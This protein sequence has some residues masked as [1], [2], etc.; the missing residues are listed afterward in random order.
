MSLLGLDVGTS[1]VKAAVHDESGRLLSSARCAVAADRPGP[2]WEQADAEMVWAAACEVI[3]AVA[4]SDAVRHDPIT[5]LAIS[6]SGDEAFPVDAGGR[7]LAPC[8]M[9]GDQRGA[10]VESSTR[11]RAARAQWYRW[12]G[13]VP[14]RMDPVNRWLWLQSEEPKIT[15]S[16]RWFLGWHEFLTLRLC[17]TPV[18]DPS[19]AAKWL[20]FDSSRGS[21][22]R[23]RAHNLGLD[24]DLL[25][26]IGS[27]GHP[28]DGLLAS[29]ARRLGIP[30][31]VTVGV[32]A[33]DSVAAALGSGC[34][35]EGTAGLVCGSWE[36]VV[37]PSR[38]GIE[39]RCLTDSGLTVLPY[40]G[41][42]G[43]A[44]VAQSPNGASVI[45]WAAGLT[46]IPLPQLSDLLQ[47]T[48]PAP[49]SA[50][51]AAHLSGKLLG[52]R[53]RESARGSITG[54]TL[55]TTGVEVVKAFAE[56]VSYDVAEAIR[57]LG[58]ANVKLSNLR[59]TGGGS[60]NPW[61]M[62]LK[63]DVTGLP[64]SVVDAAEPGCFGAVLLAGGSSNAYE[65]VATAARS[66]ARVARQYQPDARRAELHAERNR[67]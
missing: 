26:T 6:A 43:Q 46:G 22:S 47:E 34:V 10:S 59:A 37:A 17:G 4:A 63:A 11:R 64:V 21:W 40:P 25:P 19:L 33:Y 31:R 42:A 58:D 20:V 61:W 39:P 50:T 66:L 51:A 8:L 29:Q 45:T 53:A 13:H 49:S 54:L 1:T 55:G 14:S 67:R 28:I 5:A 60:R 7:P 35:D 36:V 41:V 38:V 56:A 23:R 12:C 18:T 24:P 3:Q 48:G 62:Q 57:L 32:G 27:W 44:G 16:A 65:D 52:R 15:E 30:R 2:G 9:S